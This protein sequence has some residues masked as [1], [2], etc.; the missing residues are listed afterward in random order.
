MCDLEQ[1]P[2]EVCRM[3]LG[4]EMPL[5]EP[6]AGRAA[7]RSL[8][9]VAE[10]VGRCPGELAGP[11]RVDDPPPAGLFDEVLNL[12][13]GPGAGEDGKAV[14]HEVHQL[15]RYIELCDVG[16]LAHDAERGPTQLVLKLL[17]R[18]EAGHGDSIAPDLG[19]NRFGRYPAAGYHE[20]QVFL[21]GF[22][23]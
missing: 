22:R 13:A 14:G 23:C 20:A 11:G 17:A 19:A 9:R 15:R 6:P 1:E 8:A 3:A 7:L 21:S 5:G 2:L 4:R 16:A 18:E 12:R 10:R